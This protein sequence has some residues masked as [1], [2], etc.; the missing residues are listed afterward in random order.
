M[1]SLAEH[2]PE[3]ARARQP[4]IKPEDVPA[5]VLQPVA[6]RKMRFD[7]RPERR[8]HRIALGQR[9]AIERVLELREAIRLVIG[10]A[11]EHDAVDVTKMPLDVG[12][13]RHAAVD[14]YRERRKFPLESIDALVV[15]GRE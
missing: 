5:D 14:D 10:G 15:E 8:E 12:D 6:A 7:I 1:R 4:L 9:L 11:S 3:R 13:T 2:A